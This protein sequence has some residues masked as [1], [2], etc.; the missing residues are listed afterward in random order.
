MTASGLLHRAQKGPGVG[1]QQVPG[2]ALSQ[3][4]KGV[5]KTVGVGDEHAKELIDCLVHA[6]DGVAQKILDLYDSIGVG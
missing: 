3:L 2:G 6:G 1:G 5:V 4:V